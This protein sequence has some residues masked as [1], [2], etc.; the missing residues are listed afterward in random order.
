[1]PKIRIIILLLCAIMPANI[2]IGQT[3]KQQIIRTGSGPEDLL[4]D[5]LTTYPRILI[6]TSSRR[7]EMKTYGEIEELK[8]D[9]LKHR[10]LERRG[11]PANICIGP[12]GIYLAKLKNGVFLYVISHDKKNNTHAVIRYL[13]FHDY[14]QFDAIY[15]NPLIVS[16]NALTVFSDGSFLVCNDASRHGNKTEQILGLKRAS[17]VFCD[18]HENYS[19]AA[20][21]LG[22][23][24]GMNQYGEDIY[25]SCATENKIYKFRFEKGKLIDKELLCKAKGPDN[26]RF[27]GSDIL[28]ACHLKMLKFLGHINDPDKQSPTNIFRIN[29][30]TGKKELVY[31][32]KGTNISAGSVAVEYS[33]KMFIGQIFDNHLIKT[34]LK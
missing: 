6:A 23:P 9:N 1:M 4:I 34:S 28:V 12:H 17:I 25:V 24:A 5:T 33:G 7:D 20:D 27:I 32:D 2:I 10:I 13:V 31:S 18:G 3:L 26:I 21:K 16:P 15:K 14:L 30:E 8:L 19:I 29:T 22:M 11:E